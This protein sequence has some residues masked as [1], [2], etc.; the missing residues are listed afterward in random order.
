MRTDHHMLSADDQTG[1]P[2]VKGQISPSPPVPPRPPAGGEGVP[3]N[4]APPPPRSLLQEGALA[5][6]TEPS[7]R[8]AAPVKKQ[9]Q[10]PEHHRS[11]RTSALYSHTDRA[12]AGW[13]GGWQ[14][15][16]AWATSRWSPWHYTSA[17]R[18]GQ[19]A[20]APSRSRWTCRWRLAA[21]TRPRCAERR[22][23]A[24]WSACRLLTS[25]YGLTGRHARAPTTA[26][27]EHWSSR[28]C[29]PSAA[30]WPG[31]GRTPPLP[32]ADPPADSRPALRQLQRAP[33][34]G[35]SVSVSALPASPRQL[36]QPLPGHPVCP[37]VCRHSS[38]PGPSQRLHCRCRRPGSDIHHSRL[39]AVQVI[40]VQSTGS[41]A[42]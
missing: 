6:N 11:P 8:G 34:D 1:R 22:P 24:R 28:T 10:Q 14:P 40:G 39:A 26:E 21:R 19:G 23:C 30:C 33:T 17:S 32:R 36:P 18:P 3:E 5:S 12:C 42:V 31:D 37:A 27:Q 7:G 16:P 41:A 35:S 38:G 15:R 9:Q 2:P 29:C 25:P 4:V 13:A 20:E